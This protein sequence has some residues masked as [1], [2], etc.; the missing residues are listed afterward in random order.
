MKRL[1]FFHV[2]SIILMIVIVSCGTNE[3]PQGPSGENGTNGT[4][5]TSA[6]VYATNWFSPT[7]W[8]GQDS[9]WYFN[10]T[11]STLTAKI[12]SSGVIMAYA[13]LTSGNAGNYSYIP[14]PATLF[15]AQWSFV[16][17]SYYNIEFY[18]NFATEP[19]LNDQFRYIIIPSIDTIEIT[20]TNSININQLKRMSYKD[21]CK[22]LNLHE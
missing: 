3:G 7:A 22:L 15:N 18:T 2:S 10:V 19:S 6:K 17:P 11:D 1:K 12:D 5:G 13:N 14:L 8:E 16:L 20:V 9:A 4:N 21:M